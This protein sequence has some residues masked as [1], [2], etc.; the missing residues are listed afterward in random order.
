MSCKPL[1][2]FLLGACMP[3]AACALAGAMP[4]AAQAATLTT[5]H[6]FAGTTDGSNPV[7]GLLLGA[8]GTFYGTTSTG[9]PAG[10]GVVFKMSA[11]GQE[12]VLHGFLGGADG[13]APNGGLIEGAGNTLFGT[14]TGGGAHG[15]GTVYSVQGSTETV[16]YSFAGGAGDGATPFAG[17]VADSTG[18]L[19]GT[20]SAGGKAGTGTV[21]ELVAPSVKG[22]AWTEKVLYSFAGGTDGA[23]PVGRVA[24]DKIGDLYGTTSLG[25]TS[26]YGT[27]FELQAGTWHETVLH[28]FVNGNDGGTPYAGL[29]ADA[30]GKF[31]G[32]ATQGGVSG[33]GT[34]FELAPTKVGFTF[35]VPASV[36]GWGISGT[37]RDVLLD[38]KGVIYATT[39]CD[40]NGSGSI[41]ELT[42]SAGVWT[43]TVLFNFNGGSNGQYSISNLSRK[44]KTFYGTTIG[45]GSNG[46]GTVYAFTP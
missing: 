10:L 6:N 30:S 29:V 7:D 14:T 40:G 5:I 39:H 3:I 41:Y 32:A 27:V 18:N 9:G 23:T 8:N 11:K 21:F 35:S 31:Y 20:T 34:V 15:A 28:N 25:G 45:G 16:L 22:G 4:I 43:Y 37:F 17:L 1:N 33:G 2:R 12:T 24:F 38:K 46:A 19:Y 42:R 13:A 36:P 26:G 44:G